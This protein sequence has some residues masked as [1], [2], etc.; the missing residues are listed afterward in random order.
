MRPR[1]LHFFNTE[2]F[3]DLNHRAH[4]G[5]IREGKRKLARPFDPKR[6]LHIVLR[7]SLARGEQSL[8]RARFEKRV[9]HLVYSSAE[10][11]GVRV[12]RYANSGTHLHLLIRAKSR[13]KLARFLRTAAGLI[14]REVTGAKK[15]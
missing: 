1:Q 4:G 10:R 11:A 15:G 12:Y 2:S 5:A 6:P 13:E 9:K 14:A 3:Q 7:S 8:L